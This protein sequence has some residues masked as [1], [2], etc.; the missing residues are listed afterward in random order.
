[1]Y[2]CKFY[3]TNTAKPTTESPAYDPWVLPI[4]RTLC[5]I[6]HPTGLREKEPLLLLLRVVE[7]VTKIY[8]LQ[9]SAQDV[10]ETDF[11]VVDGQLG[12]R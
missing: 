9:V 4:F 10:C 1:M 12:A 8:L 5:T 3:K 6:K 11:A 7:V 2:W